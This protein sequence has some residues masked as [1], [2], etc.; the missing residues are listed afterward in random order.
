MLLVIFCLNNIVDP[1]L[2]CGTQSPIAFSTGT[3]NN[4]SL[5]LQFTFWEPIYYLADES[6]R[7]FPGTLDEKRGRYVGIS[8]NIGHSMT[9][10]II[11]DDTNSS[12]E[13][14]VVQSA[15]PKA[16][17][18]LREDPLE[19]TNILKSNLKKKAKPKPD[20]RDQ[21]QSNHRYPTRNTRQQT[22][23]YHTQGPS[24]NHDSDND[25]QP[26][27]IDLKQERKHQ[28]NL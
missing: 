28:Y 27:G 18:S 21:G 24:H 19:F 9:F 3:I 23:N 26:T 4:I 5:M 20:E 11:T 7:H 15:I 17:A 14:S 12:I 1:N 6:E 13:R 22:P 8:E 2:A 10:I 16:T 25:I